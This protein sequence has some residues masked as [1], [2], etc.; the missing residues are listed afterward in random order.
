VE[1]AIARSLESLDVSGRAEVTMHEVY[2]DE[3]GNQKWV[4]LGTHG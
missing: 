4:Q 2:V 1:A 3:R